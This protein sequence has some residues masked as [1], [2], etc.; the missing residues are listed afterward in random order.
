MSQE[1]TVEEVP[2]L[3]TFLRN[4]REQ[5]GV[6][7]DEA[8]EATKI[9]IRVLVA[10]ENDD[11]NSLPAE[12][13]SRGFYSLYATYLD[14]DPSEIL[15]RYLE[16]RGQQPI[17]RKNHTKPPLKN[18]KEFSTY[19]E[20]ASFSSASTMSIITVV[21]LIAAAAI[22]WSLNWNPATYISAKLQSLKTKS[23]PE[24]GQLLE[25]TPQKDSSIIDAQPVTPALP[26][27]LPSIE[28]NV[29]PTPETTEQAVVAEPSTLPAIAYLIEARFNN[30]GN[31][32]IT[33]DD[34]F[35]IEKS[36][37]AGETL[38]WKAKNKIILVMPEETSGSLVLNGIKIP[39]PEAKAGKRRLTLPEDLLD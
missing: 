17:P 25:S 31:L 2:T 19:A 33:L 26:S 6:S 20:P 36:Y 29:T 14:L 18:S 35:A 10:I 12:A 11:Y 24:Q 16:S 27:K 15:S 23:L 1:N 30:S 39:L 22:C 5:K 7:L 28:F 34:G 38:Q 8:T 21:A 13:F 4:H 32:Q 9:S 37:A 3:G